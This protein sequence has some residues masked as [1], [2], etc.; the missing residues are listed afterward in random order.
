MYK[1]CII[2]HQTY[3]NSIDDEENGNQGQR[4]EKQT[5]TSPSDSQELKYPLSDHE[6][7]SMVIFFIK[8]MCVHDIVMFG[9]KKIQFTEYIL[10]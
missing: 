1:I 2:L 4:I 9:G 6:S 8:C 3:R 10:S 7:E 5:T